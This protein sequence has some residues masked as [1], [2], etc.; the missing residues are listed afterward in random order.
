MRGRSPVCR[1]RCARVLVR[2]EPSST[3]CARRTEFVRI[4]YLCTTSNYPLTWCEN[5]DGEVERFELKTLSEVD[6]ILR[7]SQAF[8]TNCSLVVIDFLV[9][10]GT[11]VRM[12]PT[13]N[14][15]SPRYIDVLSEL[16][17]FAPDVRGRGKIVEANRFPGSAVSKSGQLTNQYKR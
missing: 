6:S 4:L 16:E 1:P 13:M 8:K 9:R 7:T 15:S 10:H 3:A 5:A 11:S 12:S 14:R 17:A 2:L